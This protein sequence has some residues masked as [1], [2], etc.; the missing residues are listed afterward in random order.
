MCNW[1]Y[2][3]LERDG[4]RSPR[5]IAWVFWDFFLNGTGALPAPLPA[6]ASIDLK[7]GQ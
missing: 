6:S 1:A 2:Q 4:R 5:E 3:W 7:E